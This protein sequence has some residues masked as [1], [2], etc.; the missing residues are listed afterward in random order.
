MWHRVEL[1]FTIHD[2]TGSYE[3]RVDE[4]TV[5]SGTNVDTRNGTPT[6]VNAV[7]LGISLNELIVDDLTFNDNAG[8]APNNTFLGDLSVEQ[9]VATSDV[10]VAMTRS[11]G[12]TNFSCVDEGALSTTDYVTAASAMSDKYGLADLAA[13]PA[14]IF[15]VATRYHANKDNT[16]TCD[17][18]ARLHSGAS[19]GDGATVGMNTSGRFY[20]D[21]FET[22]PQGG[23][24]WTGARVNALNVEIER[25]A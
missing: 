20:T 5:L 16:G 13:T 21:I 2:T 15:A 4:T 9:L 23:G 18:R 12:A 10:T 8:S 11:T 22:D 25:T 19:I 17:M 3:L 1:G 14:T 6:T 7:G 24:A